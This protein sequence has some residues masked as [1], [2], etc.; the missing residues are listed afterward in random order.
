MQEKVFKD[1][2]KVFSEGERV[3]NTLY[4]KK[5]GVYY[6]RFLQWMLS[7]GV[8]VT[9]RHCGVRF[10]EKEICKSFATFN[11]R[12]RHSA[13]TEFE[14]QARKSLNNNLVGKMA[15]DSSSYPDA[16]FLFTSVEAK[17]HLARRELTDFT[18]INEHCSLI[19]FRKQ[20]VVD[21]NL[22][23]IALVVLSNARQNLL[24]IYYDGLKAQFGE[25]CHHLFSQTDSVAAQID[26]TRAEYLQGLKNIGHYFDFSNLPDGHE[27][28]NDENKG[29]PG[30]MKLQSDHNL[31]FYSTGYNQYSVEVDPAS[32]GKDIKAGGIPKSE[33]KRL[34]HSHYRKLVEEGGQLDSYDSKGKPRGGS[35]GDHWG[36]SL[37]PRKR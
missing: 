23:L 14:A 22:R 3:L 25:K 19:K 18:I 5:G 9:K 15:S 31:S 6:I 36:Q 1:R 30:K 20:S 7:H 10:R 8:R 32:E 29:I 13:K 27:L 33:A 21:R 34:R 17:E 4:D 26:V 2:D 35:S 11:V 37:G 28:R 24:T 12:A 16:K